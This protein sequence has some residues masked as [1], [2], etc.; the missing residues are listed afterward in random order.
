MIAL[1]RNI[2]ID[3]VWTSYDVEYEDWCI[4]KAIG[5]PQ[6]IRTEILPSEEEENENT[7]I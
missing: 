6:G 3:S 1:K 5:K 2:T 7:R 4:N